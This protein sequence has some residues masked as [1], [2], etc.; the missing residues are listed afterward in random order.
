[1]LGGTACLPAAIAYEMEGLF[2]EMLCS[3]LL[4]K[5]PQL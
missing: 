4:H 2:L 5:G 3:V 1:M